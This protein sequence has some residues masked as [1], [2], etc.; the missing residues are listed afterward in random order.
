MTT[1]RYL[2][3]QDKTDEHDYVFGAP[4]R[5]LKGL[6]ERRNLWDASWPAAFDQDELG[7]CTAN[8]IS[9]AIW[10][11]M[12]KQ[13]IPAWLASRLFIYWNERFLE[14]TWQTDS[15]ASLRDG[16]KTI[17][18]DGVLPETEYPYDITMF[19]NRPPQLAYAIAQAHQ[20]LMYQRVND[21]EQCKG[22]I[23]QGY[24][25]LFGVKVFDSFAEAATRRS[26][27]VPMPK[28]GWWSGEKTLGGHA[29]LCTGYDDLTQRFNLL[30]SYG[31][32]W[33]KNGTGTIP[34]AYMADP[35]LCFD[36]WT[37]RLME[38]E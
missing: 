3:K 28:R 4:R 10:F 13:G 26:G 20:V 31:R 34:Y 14:G 5:V 22:C 21:L 30:N 37:I 35:E 7:A 24:P 23:A 11:L 38:A 2:C 18:A 17:C 36:R 32:G 33:G 6:P 9:M 8:A 29:I 27:D 15:G 16:M 19:A 12:M 25:F 1:R